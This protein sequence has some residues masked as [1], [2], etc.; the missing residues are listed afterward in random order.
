MIQKIEKDHVPKIFS[1]HWLM[2]GQAD[3]TASLKETQ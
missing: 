1:T 2:T 3:I